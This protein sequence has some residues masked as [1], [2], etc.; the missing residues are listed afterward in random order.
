[1]AAVALYA[2]P[3]WRR[4]S[5]G[6]YGASALTSDEPRDRVIRGLRRAAGRLPPVRPHG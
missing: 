5:R 3:T 4:V 2:L 6:S 1:M